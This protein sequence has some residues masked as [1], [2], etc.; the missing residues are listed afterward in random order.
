MV[1]LSAPHRLQLR[2]T[3][4]STTNCRLAAEELITRRMSAV[5]VCCSSAS[6]SSVVRWASARLRACNSANSRAFSMAITAWSAKV[7]K[8]ATCRSVNGRTS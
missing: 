2:S 6:W 1:A 4:V 7:S 5:A 3:T 8:S